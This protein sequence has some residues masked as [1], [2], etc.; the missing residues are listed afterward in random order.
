MPL[1]GVI[2]ADKALSAII[3]LFVVPNEVTRS[4]N[5]TGQNWIYKLARSAPLKL[6][7]FNDVARTIVC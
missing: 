2:F 3:T 6:E 5:A 4:M 1:L 7:Q